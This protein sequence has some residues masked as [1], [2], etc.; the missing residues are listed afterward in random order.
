MLSIFSKR[1]RA[2]RRALYAEADRRGV[3]VQQLGEILSMKELADIIEG[4][5]PQQDLSQWGL[6]SRSDLVEEASTGVPAIEAA[7]AAAAGNDWHAA[8]ALLAGTDGDWQLHAAAVDAL[9]RVAANDDD[10]LAAWQAARPDDGNALVVDSVART[11][12]AWQLRG[13][14]PAA[15]TTTKQAEDFHRVIEAAEAAALRA[16]EALPDDPTPWAALVRIA[17]GR[18]YDNTEFLRVWQGVVDRAPLHRRAHEH[19]LQYWS[20]KWHG[21]HDRMIAFAHHAA[22]RSPSLSVLLVQAAFEVA[23]DDAKVWRRQNMRW[24]LNQLVDWLATDGAHSVDVRDDLGWAAMAL[25][26]SNRG[27]EAVECFRQL[28][29]Y[30]GG[31]PWRYFHSPAKQFNDYRVRACTGTA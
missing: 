31:V 25:V 9:A 24:G 13:T 2:A 1:R 11:E 17:R 6:P 16:A 14:R 28:G 29:T 23:G 5:E 19:A 10:W 21:S 20:A 15:D 27:P 18:G 7:V 12:L 4:A 30:A 22:N 26:E 8:A 3:T